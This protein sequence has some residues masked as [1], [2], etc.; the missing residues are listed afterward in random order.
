LEESVG[1]KKEQKAPLC[2]S[3]LRIA[4]IQSPARESPCF[5]LGSHVPKSTPGNINR[6]GRVWTV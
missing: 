3:V 1:S 2:S 6:I 4:V 5:Y